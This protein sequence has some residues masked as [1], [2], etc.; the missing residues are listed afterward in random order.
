[1]NCRHANVA[2]LHYSYIGLATCFSQSIVVYL[3]AL[4]FHIEF[5]FDFLVICVRVSGLEMRLLAMQGHVARYLSFRVVEASLLFDYSVENHVPTGRRTISG[6]IPGDAAEQSLLRMRK[7][8]IRDNIMI[9]RQTH[10]ITLASTVLVKM[11]KLHVAS[12]VLTSLTLLWF[13]E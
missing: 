12:K 2:N 1:M 3:A 8:R 10:P 6:N 7:R 11:V 4:S 9:M 13:S 5:D